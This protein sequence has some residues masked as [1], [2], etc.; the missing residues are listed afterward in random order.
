MGSIPIV[1]VVVIGLIWAATRYG[2]LPVLLIAMGGS[3]LAFIGSLT[4]VG[5]QILHAVSSAATAI[6]GG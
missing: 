4:T 5:V 1:A 3:A 6:G 2:F